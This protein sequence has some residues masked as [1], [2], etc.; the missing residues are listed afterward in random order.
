MYIFSTLTV[1]NEGVF[2][3][4]RLLV[5]DIIQ[6]GTLVNERASLWYGTIEYAEMYSIY[7][8]ILNST[9]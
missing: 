4:W 1:V 6:A 9:L 2:E 3:A 7:G 5:E 8:M